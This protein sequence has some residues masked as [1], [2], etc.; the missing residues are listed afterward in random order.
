MKLRNTATLFLALA[1][2]AA[3]LLAA[4]APVPVAPTATQPPSPTAEAIATPEQIPTFVPTPSPTPEPQPTA[5]AHVIGIYAPSEKTN[6]RQLLTEF[7]GPWNKGK[8]IECFEAFA[9]HED[10]LPKGRF[11]SVWQSY[12][13]EYDDADQCKI[14]YRLRFMLQ[15]SQEIKKTIRTP[16]DADDFRE[17]IEVYL[18]DDVHQTPGVRYS[19]IVPSAIH[20][21]TVCTSI[22]LTAGSKIDEVQEI[23]LAAFVYTGD[24]D[25]DPV[26]GDYIGNSSYEIA[27]HRSR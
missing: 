11:G 25:F 3:V 21:D 26:T 24:A 9:T 20:D 8:D 15:S 14:G 23:Y 19:H 13:D 4:C 27:L 2:S 22:K 16:D 18:Y 7:T 6:K 10:T 1:L 5:P 12:W 17:Y